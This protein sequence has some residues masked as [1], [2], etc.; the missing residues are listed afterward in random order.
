MN[1]SVTGEQ[2]TGIA[3]A[4]RDKTGSSEQIMFPDGFVSNIESLITFGEI[5]KTTETID[6]VYRFSSQKTVMANSSMSITLN[7]T[8][9]SNA[10]ICT[11]DDATSLI[12]SSG[13]IQ[14]TF[15]IPSGITMEITEV[16][17]IERAVECKVKIR[18]STSNEKKIGKTGSINTISSAITYYIPQ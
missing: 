16:S 1:Y 14:T 7:C 9:P 6:A 11:T 5:N 3:D 4:I 18:N 2:L 15:T 8:L 17:V 12:I 10:L 13:S